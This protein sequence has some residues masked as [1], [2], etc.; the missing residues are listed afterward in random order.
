MVRTSRTDKND[1]RSRPPVSSSHGEDQ[2]EDEID[3]LGMFYR[4]LENL[5]YIVAAALLG[6]V[7]MGVIT[8]YFITPLYKTTAKIYVLNSD[9][10]AINLSDLQIGTYLAADYQEVFNNWIVHERVIQ[11]LQLP[12]SYSELASMLTVTN[13]TDTRILYI[14]ISSPDPQEA[15]D[16]ADMYAK[17]A[18]EFIASTMDTE[19]PNLFE[20][21]LLPTSPYSPSK[22]KNIAVGFLGGLFLSCAFIVMRYITGDKIRTS[23]DIERYVGLPTLGI[24]SMQKNKPFSKPNNTNK[25]NQK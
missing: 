15:K 11:A 9:D 17:V 4:L 13:P 22:T 6:A 10:A 1:R 25:H 2:T 5:K 12:Y 14:T 23:E 3:L 20:E 18:Q 8:I 24:I 21:A 19:E 7:V 16:I